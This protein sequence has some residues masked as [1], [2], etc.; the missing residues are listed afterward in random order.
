RFPE[1]IPNDTEE[2]W[3]QKVLVHYL[4]SENQPCL[5]CGRTGTTHV[6]NPCRHVVCDHCFDGSNYSACP[7]C[8]HHVDQSSPF[9]EPPP[10]RRGAAR[11]KGVIVRGTDAKCF[12]RRD[13]ENDVRFHDRIVDGKPDEVQSGVL[14]LDDSPALAALFRGDVD[15]P[16]GSCAYALF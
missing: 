16:V 8:E 4:Q 3:W 2:L 6:L 13:G 7:S 10:D 1:G 14:K 9:F 5:F 15:L 11:C 12:V